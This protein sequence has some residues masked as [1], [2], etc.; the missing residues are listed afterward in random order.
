VIKD[1][2]GKVER[3][4]QHSCLLGEG[5]VW[6][7]R[8]SCICWLDILNGAIHQF[9]TIA[10]QH[11]I[12]EVGQ[13]I[14]CIALTTDGNFIA[15]LKEGIALIDRYSGKVNIMVKPEQQLPGNRF[16]DGKCDPAGRFWA[17][18]MALSEEPHAANLYMIDHH[19]SVQKRKTAV[20]IS[21]GLAWSLDGKTMYYI[22]TPTYE[23]TAF[24]FNV[25]TGEIGN[26]RIV[27]LIPEKEGAPDGMTIDNEGML[28][29]AHW[30]GWQVSRWNPH[31]G[32]K[33]MHISLPVAKVTSCTFGGEHLSDLYITTARVDL[34]VADLE[35]Q[36]LAGSLFV[37]RDCGFQGLPPVAYS[38]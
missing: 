16:N 37:I 23:V 7:P 5:P 24:D 19:R 9:S 13:F 17:G 11:T 28:W 38:L 31:D 32:K 4:V 33:L 30:G 36:P 27:I 1:I 15:G 6:D 8:N 22:D 14:G 25:D 21:N 10:K 2:Q 12:I 20:T 29:I 3:V 18:T 34:S 35:Q 26:E